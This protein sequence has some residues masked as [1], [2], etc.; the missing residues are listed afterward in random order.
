MYN[1]VSYY[2]KKIAV[3]AV[4]LAVITSL[5]VLFISC[6]SMSVDADYDDFYTAINDAGTISYDTDETIDVPSMA[7]ITIIYDGNFNGRTGFTLTSGSGAS[8]MINVMSSNDATIIFKNL[9]IDSINSDAAVVQA[10]PGNYT[11]KFEN[12][13]F[14]GVYARAISSGCDNLVIDG[15]K[16]TGTAG[17]QII[18]GG[19]NLELKNSSLYCSGDGLTLDASET[20]NITNSYFESNGYGNG[21]YFG[22]DNGADLTIDG[23]TFSGTS[24]YG[25]YIVA[26][27][28]VEAN[29]ITISGSLFKTLYSG[30]MTPPAIVV[31][32]SGTGTINIDRCM[33]TGLFPMSGSVV[34]LDSNMIFS[35]SNTTFESNA[36]NGAPAL[37]IM[38]ASGIIV[39][40][41]FLDNE[42]F[43]A[44]APAGSV[45]LDGVSA[46]L[47]NNTFYGNTCSTIPVSLEFTSASSVN[48]YNNLLADTSLSVPGSYSSTPWI[49]NGIDTN[50]DGSI[51]SGRTTGIGDSEGNIDKYY[52]YQSDEMMPQGPFVYYY[53]GIAG[54]LS[55]G[56]NMP[57]EGLFPSEL[58]AIMISPLG[59]A[60]GKGVMYSGT[61]KYD[62]RGAER[63]GLPD[64]GAVSTSSA[65]FDLNGGF[66]DPY[67][68]TFL[69]NYES[70][71]SEYPYQFYN[72][73]SGGYSQVATILN[74]EGSF[75]IPPEFTIPQNSDYT[76]QLLGWSTDKTATAE[77]LDPMFVEIWGG[78][79][80]VF[81]QDTIYYAI[82]GTGTAVIFSPQNGYDDVVVETDADGFV[83]SAD[84][85]QFEPKNG[86]KLT[87]WTY[88]DIETGVIAPWNSEVDAGLT[89]GIITGVWGSENDTPTYRVT[90]VNEGLSNSINVKKGDTVSKPADPTR[91]GYEFKGWFTSEDGDSQWSFSTSIY[92][93]IILY[94]QWDETFQ[95]IVTVT[96][97]P[98][99]GSGTTVI[100]AVSGK[101]V[102]TPGTPVRD[103]FIFDGWYTSQSGG[104]KWEPGTP[105][106]GNITLYAH[107]KAAGGDDKGQ[108]GNGGL[109][110]GDGSMLLAAVIASIIASIGVAGLVGIIGFGAAGI[111]KL[112]L[113]QT[114]QGM[115]ID[116]F[117][118]TSGE[119]KNRRTVVF[120][121][122]NG[123]SPWSSSVIIGRMV[124][125]PSDPRAPSGMM[126]SHWSE[127]LNGPPF[128]FQTP[129][130]DVIHLY[131]VYVPKG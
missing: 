89:T 69:Y 43:G 6:A 58:T 64:V 99:N 59:D 82:W 33:F 57:D 86:K 31:Q 38:G 44:M 120:E 68:W 2:K 51:V 17:E 114:L 35:I 115:T 23:C 76:L 45:F 105:V 53:S 75:T 20:V 122:Q 77:E 28:S 110:G 90:F 80:G 101:T 108:T 72:A 111:A 128:D 13:V 39:N 91:E 81:L 103:G 25:S 30:S 74:S 112:S 54:G 42:I 67:I 47:I 123:R 116:M 79:K 62:Q 18:A 48:M 125:K 21:I 119:E 118:D 98:T 130:T 32:G 73:V 78:I 102:S 117:I 121:P 15:C 100:N 52:P 9:T 109:L 70:Y 55:V 24:Y 19:G 104:E 85:P 27:V 14:T 113:A 65:M 84:I 66:W 106:T 93:N 40:S 4:S 95:E 94:A 3:F 16:F 92:S 63:T 124:D 50:Y 61:P 26:D 107:W 8:P 60:D 129:I 127:S 131:A 1:L 7:G 12:V 83:A 71:S 96:F 10:E 5:A 11:L 97:D 126:F 87:G 22:G 41:T 88:K 56:C 36:T 29:S 46:D 37:A 49:E 34:T